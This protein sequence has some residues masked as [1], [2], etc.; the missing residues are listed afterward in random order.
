MKN[1]IV[2]GDVLFPR[3]ADDCKIIL[4]LQH[5]NNVEVYA[6]VYDVTRPGGVPL[7]RFPSKKD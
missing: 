2:V 7:V 6:V 3:S 5:I 4:P 1:G